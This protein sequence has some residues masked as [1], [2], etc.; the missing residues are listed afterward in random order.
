MSFWGFDGGQ[1]KFGIS[2]IFSEIEDFIPVTCELFYCPFESIVFWNIGGATSWSMKDRS[3]DI[4]RD[5][6]E[7]VNVICNAFLFVVTFD[8]NNKTDS[9]IGRSLYYDIN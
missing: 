7:D 2:Y 3:F 9:R 5:W 8:F 4:F 1:F 6:H